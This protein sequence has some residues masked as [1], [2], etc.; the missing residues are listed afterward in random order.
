MASLDM[1][2]QETKIRILQCVCAD[3]T[4][5]PAASLRLIAQVSSE[6][7]TLCLELDLLPFSGNLNFELLT[8]QQLFKRSGDVWGPEAPLEV[9]R[10]KDSEP[11]GEMDQLINFFRMCQRRRFE[12]AMELLPRLQTLTAPQLAAALKDFRN[13]HFSNEYFD[14]SAAE[15]HQAHGEAPPPV[16]GAAAFALPGK[17]LCV[18]GGGCYNFEYTNRQSAWA[19]VFWHNPGV[20]VFDVQSQIWKRQEVSGDIPPIAHTYNTAHTLL[21]GRW[22]M[23]CGG[24]YGMAYNTA[25][26]LDV[27][28]WE[29]HKLRNSA[30]EDP[31]PRYF[32]ASFEHCGALF[33]WGGRNTE[34]SYCADLWRLD[35]SRKL[36]NV[37]RC[38]EIKASGDLP[39]AKFAATLT[40]CEGRFAVLFGGGVWVRGGQFKADSEVFVLNLDTFA[41]SHLDISGSVPTPRCQHAAVNLGGHLVVILGGYDGVKRCY[42]GLDDVCV[43]NVHSLAWMSTTGQATA[44]TQTDDVDAPAAEGQARHRRR[45]EDAEPE[46]SDEEDDEREQDDED[47]GMTNASFNS[48]QDILGPSFVDASNKS[49]WIRGQF[50]APRAGAALVAVSEDAADGKHFYVFGGAEYV[51]QIW[52][53]DLYKCTVQPPSPLA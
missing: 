32:A 21:G 46:G 16:W 50:P 15:Q 28:K 9:H 37:V 31:C 34:H 30:V 29:W 53:S 20:F 22:S 27:D 36:E 26:A 5:L 11:V 23:W 8:P 48:S 52:Y 25:Y 17:K 13:E 33:S 7:R 38:E 6:W 2:L 49:G 39:P 24:Y 14:S 4:R 19:E 47:D 45:N 43:L 44:P 40:N 3:A 42:M 41:W 35:P 12:P 1:L 18:L 10:T 51:H